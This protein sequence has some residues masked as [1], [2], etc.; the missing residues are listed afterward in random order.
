VV[1]NPRRKDGAWG[2]RTRT[3]TRKHPQGWRSMLRGYKGKLQDRGALVAENGNFCGRDFEAHE[4]VIG[5]EEELHL[6]V[7]SGDAQSVVGFS[8]GA[9][10]T[11]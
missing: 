7:G 1:K 2:T 3:H 4:A 9:D 10:G 6:D 8:F 11:G 5:I